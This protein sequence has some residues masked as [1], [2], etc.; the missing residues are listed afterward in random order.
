MRGDC[1]LPFGNTLGSP[2]RRGTTFAR[3]LE[4]VQVPQFLRPLSPER[5]CGAVGQSPGLSP[6]AP[7]LETAETGGGAEAGVGGGATAA[8]MSL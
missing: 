1:D 8:A 6:P 7:G 3:Q 5:G 4:K 2:A